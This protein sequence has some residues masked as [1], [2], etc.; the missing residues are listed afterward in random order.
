MIPRQPRGAIDVA[1]GMIEYR[2]M[3]ANQPHRSPPLVFLHEGLGSVSLWRDFPRRVSEACG[4]PRTLVYSRHG[5]GRSKVVHESRPATFL[6]REA[7]VV[8]PSLLERL[9]IERPILIGHSDGAS[10]ALLHAGARHELSGLVLMAPH[11]FLEDHSVTGMMAA[12]EAFERHEL[13]ERL[14]RH[15]A[16]V[17]ATFWGWSDAWLQPAMKDWNI[18]DRLP[19]IQCPILLIQGEHDEYGT[20]AQLDAIEARVRAPVTRLVLAGVGHMPH[21]EAAE[22]TIEAAASFIESC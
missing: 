15:H 6:H 9:E 3:T 18:E 12:R 5:Y 4:S 14:S 1:G 22:R 8:L 19:S 17:D 21:F 11:V 10:I 13:R 2:V 7:D 16:D 20:L